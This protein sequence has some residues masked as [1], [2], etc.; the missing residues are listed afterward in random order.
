[1]SFEPTG[2]LATLDEL[3]QIAGNADRY[4]IAFSGGVDSTALLSALSVTS[5]RHRRPLLAVHVDHRLQPNSAAW[6][7]HCRSI[8][9]SLGVD[10]KCETVEVRADTG[11]GPEAAARSVRYAAL[12]AYVEPGTWLLSA[13]HQDDQAET[14]LLN[15]LRGS[16]A[17]GIAGIPAVRRIGDG[18][19][20][21]PLLRVS[22]RDLVNYVEAA[23]LSSLDDPSND[24]VKFDRNYLRNEVLPLLDARWPNAGAR[25]AKSA[26]YAREASQLMAALAEIDIA[27]LGGDAARLSVSRLRQFHLLR[28][29]NV[30]RHAI[31]QCSLD[32]IPSKTLQSIVDELLPA[33]DDA[34]PQV[35]WI[36]SEARRYRDGLFLLKT[37][38]HVEFAG[39]R[40]VD[41]AV[42][43]GPGLGRLR[44]V[45]TDKQGLS[46]SVAGAGL[47]V[48][49]RKGGEEIKLCGHRHTKKLKKLL[50][51][52]G[53]VPWMRDRI[54]L[55]YCDG[56]LVAVADIGVA[57]HAAE[58]GG[59]AVEWLDRPALN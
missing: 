18:W 20:A 15:L 57:V 45:P 48:Q 21:R 11:L 23:G 54:P 1:M 44:L 40:I 14:L 30:L 29:K 35:Q 31:D 19:I 22:R 38:G 37:A 49:A 27:T 9:A 28:Q 46:R 47:S 16:G 24:E 12:T 53:V 4:V 8:C 51:E 58:I 13:H 39:R 59:Y 34:E 7:E 3:E 10:F 5:D 33:R 25:L 26:E 32:A 56:Q 36:D 42:D 6:A 52:L 50:Q 55:L 41:G 2:L 43:L 17:D